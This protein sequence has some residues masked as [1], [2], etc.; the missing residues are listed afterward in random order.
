MEETRKISKRTLAFKRMH[1]KHE[2]N[3]KIHSLKCYVLSV[4]GYRYYSLFSFKN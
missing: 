4:L 3:L 2:N 1:L